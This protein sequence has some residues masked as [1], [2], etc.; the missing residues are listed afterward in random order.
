MPSR[1]HIREVFLA[2]K[3]FCNDRASTCPS[4]PL[5]GI[6]EEGGVVNM[7]H[8]EMEEVA[9]VLSHVRS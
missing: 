1:Q 9:E 3:K 5:E 2:W 7:F 4:C 6:C 8:N